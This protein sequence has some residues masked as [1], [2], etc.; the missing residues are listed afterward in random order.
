M[1]TTVSADQAR[2]NW[3]DML[4]SAFKGDEIVIERYGKPLAVVVNYDEWAKARLATESRH[5]AAAND[6][7]GSWVPGSQVGERMP[8]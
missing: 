5:I 8:E 3:R 6:A 2:V 1:V 4:D 7:A